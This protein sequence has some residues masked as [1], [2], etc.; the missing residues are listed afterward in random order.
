MDYEDDFGS[1]DFRFSADRFFSSRDE[2]R[3]ENSALGCSRELFGS[4][5]I[6]FL[7]REFTADFYGILVGITEK[8]EIAVSL[9]FLIPNFQISYSFKELRKLLPHGESVRIFS[10]ISE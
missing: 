3:D 10:D 2:R 9:I 8:E 7:R 6:F 1:D 4:F 5:L